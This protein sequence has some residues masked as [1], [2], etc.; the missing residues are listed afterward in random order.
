MIF[1]TVKPTSRRLPRVASEVP[2]TRKAVAQG[3][4]AQRR[5]K[6]SV[7]DASSGLLGVPGFRDSGFRVLGLRAVGSLREFY[8]LEGY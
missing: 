1:V 6:S 4:T 7:R 5:P 8:E 2:G 3:S